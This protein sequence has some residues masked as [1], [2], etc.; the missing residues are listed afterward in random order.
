MDARCR[1]LV[2]D[3]RQYPLRHLSKLGRSV[4]PLNQDLRLH[5]GHQMRRLPSAA[6]LTCCL[7]I[8]HRCSSSCFV[9]IPP[10]SAHY[11]VSCAHTRTGAHHRGQT[12]ANSHLLLSAPCRSGRHGHIHPGD[13]SS[14][15]RKGEG[16]SCQLHRK[17]LLGSL[18]L[19]TS[20]R[21][22]FFLRT[23][24]AHCDAGGSSS[25][26]KDTE[27]RMQHTCPRDAGVVTSSTMKAQSSST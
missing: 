21:P 14:G 5:N 4:S 26:E 1:Q 15:R 8:P 10:S 27:N 13:M 20:A 7:D 19:P 18:R 17:S 24:C 2:V 11:R 23:L 9:H 6:S 12:H 22:V 25:V 16:G 3:L